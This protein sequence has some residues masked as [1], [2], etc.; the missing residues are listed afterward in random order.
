MCN[1]NSAESKYCLPMCQNNAKKIFKNVLMW[2]CADE[3][4]IF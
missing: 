3:E 1:W 4:R 2:E